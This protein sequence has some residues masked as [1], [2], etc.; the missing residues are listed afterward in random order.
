MRESAKNHL[1]LNAMAISTVIV[2]S[3]FDLRR[4]AGFLYALALL[5]IAASEGSWAAEPAYIS[6]DCPAY[7]TAG[8]GFWERFY[9]AY[10]DEWGKSAPV[11]DPNAPAV[12]S[13]RPLPFPP[14]PETQPPYP[15]TDWPYGGSQTIG[16]SIPNAADSPLMTALAPSD[17]GKWLNESH[18]QIY[19]WINTGFNLSTANGAK[20]GNSP[21]AYI[22]KPNTGE[23]DQAVV[24]IERVPDTVQQNHADWGFRF[25]ASYGESN[26]FTTAYGVAS[27]QLLKHNF[28]NI[29]DFPMVY[30]E[31]YIP[32]VAEGLVIRTGRFVAVPDIEA[33]LAVNNY[34]YSHSMTYAYDNYTNTGIIGSV[35]MTRNW[36]L[37]AGITAGTETV[38]WNGKD[39][40]TQPSLTACARWNSDDSWHN[41]YVCANG[42]NNGEWGYNNLQWYGFTTY[43]KLSDKW[44]LA[45]EVW[46]MH[47]DHVAAVGTADIW[48]TPG[49]PNFILNPVARPNQAFCKPGQAFCTA[50]EYTALMFINYRIGDLDNLTFRTE[51]YNDLKGQRTGIK[52]RYANF[53]FGLQHWFSPSIVI[54]PEIASYETTD[55]TKAFGRDGLN[56]NPTQS[57]IMIFAVDTIIHF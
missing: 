23:L 56:M 32:G 48:N 30:G 29:Y 21:A 11:T 54:R 26:R 47:Q 52:A 43:H 18:V 5:M 55:G 41:V 39:P 57:Q 15:F 17:L 51:Y 14:A 16:A 46:D 53:A 24:Y 27:Y 37:Q 4:K 25:A 9:K 19:G 50:E 34:T 45:I 44:H 2:D 28:E 8:L 13:R 20:D 1:W 22:Y 42:I 31:V 12:V 7:G 38:P 36:V 10:A 49:S 33:Q 3:H 6:L 35:Q 40:G